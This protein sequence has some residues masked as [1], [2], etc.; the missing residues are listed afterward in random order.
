[1]LRL[2]GRALFLASLTA[3]QFLLAGAAFAQRGPENRI[4]LAVNNARVVGLQGNVHPL[5]RAEYDRGR[6]P[7]S[8]LLGH[9]AIF[10]KRTP[11]Q[12]AALERL[13]I[14]QQDR[15][16]PNYH[17]WLTPEEFGSRF[18]LSQPDMDKVAGWLR[19]RGFSIEEIP[20]SRTSIAFSGSAAQIETAFQT[21]IHRYIVDGET[22]YA[23]ATSPS[24]PEAFADVVLALVSLNDFRPKAPVSAVGSL[25][26]DYTNSVSG[27]HFLTPD[28]FATIYDLKPL[29]ANGVDG[30][31][32]VIAIMGQTDWGVIGADV[33]TFWS[34]AGTPNRAGSSAPMSLPLPLPRPVGASPAIFTVLTGADPGTLNGDVQEASL[35]IEW[36]GA[37]ARNASL[38]Y[39]NSTSAFV[40]LQYAV[41]HN[42]AP[43]I[44]ISYS[45]CEQN[46]SS[47][48][49]MVFTQIG[50]QANAQGETILASSG[51]NGAAG[52]DRGVS[53]ATRGLS[54]HYP[55]ALPYV[56]GVGGTQFNEASGTYWSN[57]NNA[58]NGSAMSY[59]PEMAWNES[60]TSGL[61]SSG[62][63]V[64]NLFQKPG[65]QAGPGVPNDGSRD[66]PDV[67]LA[68][69]G[70]DG[71]L[72]CTESFN[73]S[74]D[75]FSPTCV[76]G[77]HDAG[78]GLPYFFGTSASAPAFAGIVALLDQAT[79]SS[80]G[81]INS[82]L[83]PLALASPG[84]FHDVMAGN[85]RVACQTN[86]PSTNC[87]LTGAEAGMIGYD[88]GPGYDLV[89]GLGSVDASVLVN[90]WTS[91]NPNPD[92]Q[93]TIAPASVNLTRGSSVN[94]QLSI[95]GFNGFTAMP[96]VNCNVPPLFVGVTCS[97]AFNPSAKSVG[98]TISSANSASF[99]PVP[100]RNWPRPWP[101]AFGFVCLVIAFALTQFGAQQTHQT[102][103]RLALRLALPCS[104]AIVIGCAGGS[105]G[106]SNAPAVSIQLSPARVILGQ[107]RSVQFTA[108]VQTSSNQA[109]TWSVAP[110][111]GTVSAS[112]VYTAPSTIA[113]TQAVVVTATSNANPSQTAT[114]SIQL[115]T[116]AD[117]SL[118]VTGTA[119]GVNHRVAVP[120]TLVSN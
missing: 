35:D 3:A 43:V 21:E 58:V 87:P 106:S 2:L 28:D 69:A 67:A 110:Q 90:Q 41:Q 108:S 44:T 101:V 70:H 11:T 37:V 57:T 26:S 24:V 66:V 63:G 29:Y 74:A 107:G 1:M 78:G 76:N 5:A 12:Q 116:P 84:A 79:N 32:Q 31:G 73:P 53:T 9:V 30:S 88:A 16:S 85:N 60:S 71:Y 42:L 55:A 100:R 99:H 89:T 103:G 112:G 68:S 119:N 56:T 51:D 109:V 81:N 39:V 82:I 75:T 40:S 120:M 48:D 22:H 10:F 96:A 19:D 98:L 33:Q 80:Q 83:Y 117:D 54:V 111:M 114:A 13:L 36:A 18:G 7:A 72:V 118:A 23:N 64:S 4:A 14:E 91:V 77:F 62:G 45:E 46:V 92:F 115:A 93:M 15:S 34:E 102:A 52:C 8:T 20:P 104:L 95:F 59:I 113:T 25:K 97:L 47:N 94:A 65:W 27:H 49:L 50:Q 61:A 17:R 38:V 6:V 86:P 105:S